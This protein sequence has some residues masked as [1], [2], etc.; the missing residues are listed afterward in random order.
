M[1]IETQKQLA[2]YVPLCI[3]I[4]SMERDGCMAFPG[5][6]FAFYSFSYNMSLNMLNVWQTV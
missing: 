1:E 4:D 6:S 5:T 2:Q 3:A